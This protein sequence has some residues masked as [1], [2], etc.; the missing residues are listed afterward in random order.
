[1]KSYPVIFRDYFIS[2]YKNRVI[3]QSGFHSSCHVRVESRCSHAFLV[4]GLEPSELEFGGICRQMI[5][6]VDLE[7]SQLIQ[8]KY[9]TE[10]CGEQK[11]SP[12]SSGT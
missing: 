11:H 5:E 10:S 12:N 2:Q 3:N 9:T 6:N 1:M 4:G 8:L 7:M